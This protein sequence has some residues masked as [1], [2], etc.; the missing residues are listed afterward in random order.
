[1][2]V[3]AL[4]SFVLRAVAMLLVHESTGDGAGTGVH[5]LVSTPAGK[6]DVPVVQLQ[7]DVAGCV[8]EIPADQDSAGVGVGGDCGN[9]EQLA[10]VVLDT[11]KED[12]SQLVGVLVDHGCYPLGRDGVVVVWLDFEH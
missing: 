8:G 2:A 9:V 10:A 11:G 3:P 4:Q 6:V 1:V 12:Q 5:I 7:L